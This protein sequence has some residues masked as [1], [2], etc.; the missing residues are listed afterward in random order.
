MPAERSTWLES[1][2]GL[3]KPLTGKSLI[4]TDKLCLYNSNLK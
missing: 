2:L 3:S 4:F 1:E